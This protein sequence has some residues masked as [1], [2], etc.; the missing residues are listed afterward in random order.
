[1]LKEHDKGQYST[2]SDKKLYRFDIDEPKSFYEKVAK[3]LHERSSNTSWQEIL[4]DISEFFKKP[5]V[6][7]AI[8]LISILFMITIKYDN[9]QRELQ[10]LQ[11]KVESDEKIEHNL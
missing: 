11:A 2:K 1:M 7:I 5:S 3:G 10:L 6:L 9:M 4:K 8:L